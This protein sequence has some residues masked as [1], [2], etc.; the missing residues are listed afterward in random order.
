MLLQKLT[1]PIL[2]TDDETKNSGNIFTRWWEL[3][4]VVRLV[5]GDPANHFVA[6]V[7]QIA[8]HEARFDAIT[9]GFAVHDCALGIRGLLLGAVQV[10]LAVAAS[11]LRVG[12]ERGP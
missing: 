10:K 6:F 3:D 7:S 8:V 12:F 11:P 2:G 1:L 4:K 5:C 9:C